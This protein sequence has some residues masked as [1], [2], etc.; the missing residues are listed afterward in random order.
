MRS[1]TLDPNPH[2]YGLIDQH[3]DH[4]HFDTAQDWTKSRDG[5]ANELGGGHA[6]IGMM[7]YQGDNWPADLS[8]PALHMEHA[9]PARE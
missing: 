6:H 2:V 4:W 7:I 8:W 5:A 1:H 3:A 9:R